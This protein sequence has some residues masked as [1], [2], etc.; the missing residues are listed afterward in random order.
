MS[1]RWQIDSTNR[2]VFQKSDYRRSVRGKSTFW[3]NSLLNAQR[4]A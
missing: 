3:E 4:E 2:I 1:L